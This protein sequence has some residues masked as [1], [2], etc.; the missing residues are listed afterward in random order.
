MYIVVVDGSDATIYEF[1]K[2]I[3]AML[4]YNEEIELQESWAIKN[5]VYIAEV[6]RVHND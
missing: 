4:K 3:D 1:E 2:R 6:E 5:K